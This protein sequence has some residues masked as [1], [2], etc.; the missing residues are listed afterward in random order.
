MEN[1]NVMA[2]C[3][4]NKVIHKDD[5]VICFMPYGNTVAK[6][7]QVDY[8]R[9]MAWLEDLYDSDVSYIWSIDEMEKV[10]NDDD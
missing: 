6:V 1:G 4:M 10:V 9:R 8:S 5:E 2:R 3:L 7:I